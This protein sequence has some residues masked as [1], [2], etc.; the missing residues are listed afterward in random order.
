MDFCPVFT[1]DE[2][3]KGAFVLQRSYT[4]RCGGAVRSENGGISSVK[5]VR[6]QLAECPRFLEQRSSAPG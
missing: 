3:G 4:V 5:L 1:L 2:S 6:I